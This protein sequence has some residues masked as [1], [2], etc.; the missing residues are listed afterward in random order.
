[1]ESCEDVSRISELNP[2]V[3]YPFLYPSIEMTVLQR[4]S[5]L[6]LILL[7]LTGCEVSN[8]VEPVE[9]EEQIVGGVNLTEVFAEP[10][11]A[12]IQSVLAEWSGR[13]PVASNVT[14]IKQESVTLSNQVPATVS[15]VSHDVEGVLHYGAVIA[16]DGLVPG[17]APVM[18]YAHGGDG[19][20]SVDGEALFLLSLFPDLAPQFVHVVPSFRDEPLTF[21]GQTWQ[22]EG[23]PSPWDKDVDDAFALI[24]VAT[25]VAPAADPSRVAVLGMSRGAGVGMLMAARSES[26]RQVLGFFGPTD[27]FGPFVQEVV[28][29][30]LE[31]NPRQLP[32]LDYLSDEFVVP[33]QDGG[34]SLADLRLELVRRSPIL[35]L[36]R[37][38]R[39]QIHHGTADTIVPVSQAQRM[40]D[41]MQAAGRGSDTFEAFLYEGGSHSPF[42]LEGSLQRG[43]AFMSLMLSDVPS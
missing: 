29:E 42:T 11:T 17:S 43:S 38:N 10:T 32:G 12:E 6:L 14:V 16:P 34:L 19:G 2:S 28:T 26:V 33:Y 23:P 35:F 13:N 22:S 25:T 21:Q 39:L 18:V 40:I 30:I 8:S 3:L 1:L 4:F 31:G 9:E 27:F 36:D 37:I 24:D 5:S 7:L 41:A 20:V 15:I